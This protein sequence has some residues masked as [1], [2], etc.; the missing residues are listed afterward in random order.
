M[1][2]KQAAEAVKKTQSGSI[3][4]SK[5]KKMWK[6]KLGNAFFHL[7]INTF[8]NQI[9]YIKSSTGTLYNWA[10]AAWATS[11]LLAPTTTRLNL[12]AN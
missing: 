6:Q 9:H 8:P 11:R 4:H 5:S 2:H 12:T 3:H 1:H 7:S 10:I